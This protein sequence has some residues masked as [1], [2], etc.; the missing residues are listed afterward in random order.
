M[1]GPEVV[2]Q[3]IQFGEEFGMI[4]GSDLD[5]GPG[6]RRPRARPRPF[7]PSCATAYG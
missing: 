1:S 7:V 4:G 2:L 3:L 5:E 6:D